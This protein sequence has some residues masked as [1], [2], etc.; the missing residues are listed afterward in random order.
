M[1]DVSF[2]I[3]SGLKNII[4]KELITDDFIAVFE[5]VKN[6]FDAN[7]LQ[8]EIIFQGQKSETPCIIIKD[9]GDG[10]D[11]DDLRNKWLFVAYSVK[12]FEQDY[13]DKIKSGR[14]YAGAKGIGRFSCDRLGTKL[15]LITR[16]KVENAPYYVL[17]V[18][19]NRFEENPEDEFQTIPAQLTKTNALHVPQFEFGTVLEIL[20][21]RSTDWD[22]DK[23][24]KLRRSLERLI[25]PN[26]GNDVDNFSIILKVPDEEQ[27]DEVIKQTKP[28]EPWNIVNGPIKNFLFEALELK[29]TQI[30]LEIDKDGDLLLTQLQD[31]GTLIYE[32]LEHNPY[33]G[34]LYNIRINLFYL[35]QAA[36][37]TFSRRMGMR[38]FDYG[39]V[40]LYK[41][42]FRIQPFGDVGDDSLGINYRKNQ[43][44]FKRLGL[45]DLSGRIEI[46]G[47]NP[48]F[49]ETSSRDG[50]LIKNKAFSNLKELFFDYSLKRL[51]NFVIELAKFGKGLEDLPEIQHPESTEL[52]QIAFDIIVK[53]TQ[54]K[55]VV[56]I[57]YDPNILDVLENRSSES[58]TALL[59]N[60]KRISAEQNNN[61]LHKEIS[62]AEKQVTFLKK[63]KEEAEQETEIERERAKQAEQE[64]KESYVKAREAEEEA[65]KAQ[66]ETQ[67]AQ[68]ETQVVKDKVEVLSTQNL[69][70]KSVL[71]KDLQHV[72]NLHHTIGQDA[73]TIDQF[74]A[75]LLGMLK[76]GNRQLKP[77]RIK[78]DLERISYVARKIITVSRFATQANFRADAEEITADLLSYIREYLLNI[79]GG[80]VLD[81]YEQRIEILFN[82]S[83][84]VEF[85]TR[86]TPIK[87]S[88]VFDN[89]ISNS[90]KHK[91]KIITVSIIEQKDDQ[92]IVSFKDDGRG[93]PRKNIPS[94]FQIGFSTTDGSGLGLHHSR[95]IMEEMQ[96]NIILNED[97]KDGA[98][99]ILTFNKQ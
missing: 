85:V 22:R 80:F 91:S 42:G 9:N 6:S 69:F 82:S 45:R 32:L 40:F 53:L 43:G 4:G 88:I 81:P 75:N 54:S 97:Y 17:N 73:R 96:S 20:N 1:P 44:F 30:Q 94:L 86:F 76:D 77:E 90:R 51:E 49:Q 37:L 71:S 67:K 16:K 64:A 89:L 31:R 61:E 50:G 93:I 3:S 60:L 29:T 2:R 19:W 62:K 59:N 26:Q 57:H 52:R 72:L 25:N 99:F 5:L 66:T 78:A 65:R 18:D 55:D 14:V 79:Y 74:V 24:L 92:L 46:N 68:A 39:S 15:R 21:L 83:K 23:L 28:N 48:D 8:V 84:G 13:R 34:V 10:M 35:N 7:A 70:L 36:K 27:E 56:D 95:T 58:V 98:E 87:V 41:N 63:A 47:S 33:R 12:K 38:I 11:E